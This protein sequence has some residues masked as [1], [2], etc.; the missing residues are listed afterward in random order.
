MDAS[1]CRNDAANQDL[2]EAR[3]GYETRA[4]ARN[5]RK[6][7]ELEAQVKQAE[8]GRTVEEIAAEVD[9]LRDPGTPSKRATQFVRT[10]AESWRTKMLIAKALETVEKEKQNIVTEVIVTDEQM[11][12]IINYNN[13]LEG[14]INTVHEAVQV[15][16]RKLTLLI[17][18][19]RD[20]VNAAPGASQPAKTGAEENETLEAMQARMNTH[21]RQMGLDTIS[22]MGKFI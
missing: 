19:L 22:Q 21:M 10:K 2:L 14:R 17:Q 9:W 1:G 11:G 4:A 8:D 12:K 5:K 16:N 18:I 15:V 3:Q 7:E 6:V 20:T 13:T